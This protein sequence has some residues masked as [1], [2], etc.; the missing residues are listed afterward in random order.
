[1]SEEL[2][3]Y[4]DI[5]TKGRVVLKK[6]GDSFA[7]LTLDGN[8]NVF[9]AAI[10]KHSL[11]KFED[12]EEGQVFSYT[13]RLY[14]PIGLVGKYNEYVIESDVDNKNFNKTMR[15]NSIEG[16]LD[17]RNL[18][19]FDLEVVETLQEGDETIYLVSGK[20]SYSSG[21]KYKTG[22]V[23]YKITEKKLVYSLDRDWETL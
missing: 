5:L 18:I 8:G 11:E 3:K 7:G 13:S 15:A 23:N 2:E 1:M 12:L 10:L 16:V 4:K 22:K 20:R 14:E 17:S 9:L 6:T 19:G 21:N